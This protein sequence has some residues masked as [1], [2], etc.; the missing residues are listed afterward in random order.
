MTKD[1]CTYACTQ[2]RDCPVRAA[3]ALRAQAADD[4]LRDK[5]LW[6]EVLSNMVTLLTIVGWI[7]FACGWIG[8]FWYR[9]AP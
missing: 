6:R 7:A 4:L 2:G 1:C 8:Y 5:P 3:R 9:S